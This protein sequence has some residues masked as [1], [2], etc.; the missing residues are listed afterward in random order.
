MFSYSYLLDYEFQYGLLHYINSPLHSVAVEYNRGEAISLLNRRNVIAN[1]MIP[2]A[3]KRND[4]HL[5]EENTQKPCTIQASIQ[6]ANIIMDNDSSLVLCNPPPI[7]KEKMCKHCFMKKACF[8]YHATVEKGSNS[9]VHAD[10]VEDYEQVVKLAK[11]PI[12]KEYLRKWLRLVQL[13]K[14]V[15]T[16]SHHIWTR[17]DRSSSKC[18]NNAS[19]KSIFCLIVISGC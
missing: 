15:P 19:T 13:E 8:V 1:S 18:I 7:L 6:D 9:D 11:E 12:S 17:Q 2:V 14:Q 10:V 5:H 3:V 16:E 4:A